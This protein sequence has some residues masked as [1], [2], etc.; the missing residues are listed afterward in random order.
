MKLH[1]GHADI[2]TWINK[3]EKNEENIDT[4][5]LKSVFIDFIDKVENKEI[6]ISGL[7]NSERKYLHML[8]S[9]CGI[10]SKSKGKNDR[11]LYL[12][13]KEGWKFN[14]NKYIR[15]KSF[16]YK[17][18]KNLSPDEIFIRKIE[19]DIKHVSG[20]VCEECGL[21]LSKSNILTG[22]YLIFNLYEWWIKCPECVSKK[23]MSPHKEELIGIYSED[24]EKYLNI[25]DKI[26]ST[27]LF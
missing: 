9:G 3:Y 7:N 27:K 14:P 11:T 25:M 12:T 2:L 21:E 19:S 23:P 18:Q 8:S 24:L 20:E 1:Y 15:Q 22:S 6:T 13:K 4:D 16:M 17:R 5:S 10:K 26:D